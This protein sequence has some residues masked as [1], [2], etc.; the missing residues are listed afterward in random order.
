MGMGEGG[1]A[2]RHTFN[3]LGH[4]AIYGQDLK[5]IMFSRMRSIPC[6]GAG[7]YLYFSLNRCNQIHFVSFLKKYYKIKK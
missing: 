4:P 6:M 2:G 5:K 7:K 1:G 3:K